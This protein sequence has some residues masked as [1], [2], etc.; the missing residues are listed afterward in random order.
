[1]GI[2]KFR[3]SYRNHSSCKTAPARQ[4][5]DFLIV[6]TK[7]N[8][9]KKTTCFSV[10][11][12]KDTIECLLRESQEKAAPPAL[13]F[14][15]L[16]P[17]YIFL[18]IFPNNDE[19]RNPGEHVRHNHGSNKSRIHRNSLSSQIEETN[20]ASKASQHKPSFFILGSFIHYTRILYHHNLT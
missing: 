10:F 8:S 4:A 20:Y 13:L 15:P 18:Y 6:R 2:F 17:I 12:L 11:N 7:R 9:W 3:R 5:G 14:P 19:Y 16:F 1:M